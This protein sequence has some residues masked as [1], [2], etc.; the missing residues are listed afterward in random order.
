[1][2]HPKN[3]K[4]GIPKLDS[5][6]NIYTDGSR[7]G[8]QQSGAAVSVWKKASHFGHDLERLLPGHD[9]IS[10]HLKD[11][12]IFHCEIFGITEAATWINDWANHFQIK[13]VVIN[14][15]SLSSIKAIDNHKVKSKLVW[16]AIQA[17]NNASKKVDSL[18]IRWVKAHL[19]D[20]ILHRGNYFADASAKEGAQGLD[21]ES[22]IFDGD[23]PY[24]SYNVIKS[25]IH[26]FFMKE[27][28]N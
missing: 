7:L 3:P 11:S 28:N 16:K 12:S 23:L 17:L 1:M 13:T 24:R 20:S 5:N 27:W 18:Q 4:R 8:A 25:E 26:G 15:D 19:D 14:V 6:C 9:K 22:Y 10:F 21:K 2:F